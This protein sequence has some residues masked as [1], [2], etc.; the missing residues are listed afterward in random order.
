[1][2]V[3][4]KRNFRYG[5]PHRAVPVFRLHVIEFAVED[6]DQ[7]Q[8]YCFLFPGFFLSQGFGLFMVEEETF[9][10]DGKLITNSMSKYRVPRL[11]DIP[12]QMSVHLLKESENPKAVYSSKVRR[13]LCSSCW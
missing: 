2:D 10:P 13:A 4:S 6:I 7:L 1:M 9:T 3:K 5:V 8:L 12:Q 11:R